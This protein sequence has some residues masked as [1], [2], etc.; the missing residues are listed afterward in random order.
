MSRTISHVSILAQKL[1]DAMTFLKLDP[2]AATVDWDPVQSALL[3]ARWLA[4]EAPQTE[5]VLQ[6]LM[7]ELETMKQADLATRNM[8]MYTEGGIREELHKMGIVD[9]KMGIF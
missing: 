9:F 7:N 4:C 8:D 2:V 5:T 6:P 3:C 1:E